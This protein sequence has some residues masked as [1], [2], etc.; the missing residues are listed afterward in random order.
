MLNALVD[1]ISTIISLINLALIVWVVL[2]ALLHFD[3]VNRTS[4]VVNTIYTTLS[5]LLEPMLTP[6][7]RLAQKYLPFFQGIDISP[8]ILWL[9][10]R[11]IRVAIVSTFYIDPLLS[12]AGK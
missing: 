1:L 3:I 11:F 8:V 5:R 7:R 12:T 4:P 2:G 9:V 10:L 6:I